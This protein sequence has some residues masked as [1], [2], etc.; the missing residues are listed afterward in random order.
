M[1][2]ALTQRLEGPSPAIQIGRDLVRRGVVVAPAAV[3]VGAL[4]GGADGAASVLYGLALV[5]V[6]FLLA[7]VM[8]GS[9]ARVSFVLMGVAAL[10]G[11][12]VRLA[13]I[14]VAVWLVK[15]ASWV[16]LVPLGLTIIVSHLGLLFWELRYVSGSLAYPGLKPRPEPRPVAPAPSDRTTRST[17]R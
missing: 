7:A 17:P 6:N 8:L 1:T 14:F 15:D 12:L 9:A 5:V 13:L 11:F 10:F 4:L 16:S 2:E 3:V